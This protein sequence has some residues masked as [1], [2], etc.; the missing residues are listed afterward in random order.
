MPVAD[1]MQER[2]AVTEAV[3]GLLERA[4]EGTGGTF[5]VIGEAGLGKTTVLNNAQRRASASFAIGIGRG[6]PMEASL[7]FGLLAQVIRGL[8]GQDVLE[9]PPAGLPATDIRARRFYEALR[10]LEHR[11]ATPVLLALDDLHWADPDSLA[12]LFFLCRRI[13]SVPVAVIGTARPWPAAAQEVASSL[14][15]EG[16]AVSLHLAP[17]SFAAASNLLI[18]R[19][20]R[21]LPDAVVQAAWG[22]CAGN[23]LLIEQAAAAISR[24]ED[25]AGPGTEDWP[26]VSAGLLLARFADLS[27]AE[28]RCAQA[29]SVIGVRF[30]PDLAGEV[31]QVDE[32]QTDATLDA[33]SRGGLIRDVAGGS[34]EFVH[35][36]FCQALYDD[37]TPPM[38]ARFHAR[39]FDLLV[40]RGMQS[41]AAEHAIRGDLA[42]HS[43]AIAVVEAAGRSAL[44]SGALVT[45]ATRLEAAVHL[46]GD[47]A[48]RELLLALGEVLI[49]I[50]RP[51]QA[52]GVYERVLIDPDIPIASRAD[53]LRML[54]R[55]LS[56]GGARER[57]AARFTE[58]VEIAR[59]ESP[60]AAVQALLDHALASWLSGGPTVALPLAVEARKLARRGNEVVRRRAQGAWGFLAFQTGDVKGLEATAAAS[61]AIE[62]DPLSNLFDLCWTWGAL[63]VYGSVARWAERFDEAERVVAA[64]LAAAEQ[65][66][67][68]EAIVT[69]LLGQVDTLTRLGPLKDALALAS[70]ASSLT[71][72]LPMHAFLAGLAHA[73]IL[74]LMDRPEESD[75]WCDRIEA[76]A[77]A[78]G[79]WLVLLRLWHIRGLRLL[80]QGRLKEARAVYVRLEEVNDRY[81]I[82]EP[83]MV[84]WARS[85]IAA[86]LACEQVEDVARLITWLEQSAARLPCRWPRIVALTGRAAL[87]EHDGDHERAE[88]HFRAAIALH[89]EVQL[90]LDLIGTLTL[91]GAFLRRTGHAV[92]A[93]RPLGDAVQLAEASGAE[94]LARQA[95]AELTVAGGRR[96][97]AVEDRDRLTAQEERV[98]RFAAAGHSNEELARQLSLSVRT[99]ESHLQRIYA[100]LGIRSRRQLIAMEGW[101]GRTARKDP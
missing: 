72:L 61:Q 99:I 93:R 79:E 50:G 45:A 77:T 31:A 8:G 76:P 60:D 100:K 71:D 6:S 73:Y 58:A 89:R 67:A 69:L 46:A 59:I 16:A 56:L 40:R 96:R 23:P 94:W 28:M 49:A 68:A 37:L 54:G 48:S 9:P 19:V 30:R 47:R 81:G 5:F 43:Q 36:L 83:C 91:Y 10:W 88:D 44:R 53:A 26:R 21:P 1:G 20:G 80:D 98:A 64:G 17:L 97:R 63:S 32:N 95:R 55:A 78:R 75:T 25:V 66:G 24:G 11:A 84:R 4:R 22:G 65:V 57:A 39:A 90:P 51:D 62:A 70:R 86:H 29:A 14:A 42:G 27:G 87:A 41:E 18:R 92:R 15:A 12:L 52:V 85:A 38:R 13:A 7:P 2:E 82:G 34:V 101:A 33:L 3:A 74:L 35:P